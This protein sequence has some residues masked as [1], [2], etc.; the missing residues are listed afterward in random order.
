MLGRRHR[1]I[2]RRLTSRTPVPRTG[3]H[4]ASVRRVLPAGRTSC[5]G[6][7]GTWTIGGGPKGGS[8]V[9]G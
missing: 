9:P 8:T 1:S 5:S 7:R 4:N 2:T 6:T 3:D